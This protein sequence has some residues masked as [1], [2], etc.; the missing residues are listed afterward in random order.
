MASSDAG[1]RFLLVLAD[2]DTAVAREAITIACADHSAGRCTA[3]L[4]VAL[5]PAVTVSWVGASDWLQLAPLADPETPS[6]CDILLQVDKLL[7]EVAPGASVE[8]VC[9]TS[10][11]NLEA[12][13]AE[14][15]QAGRDGTDA[16]AA[17][18]QA[19]AAL[20]AAAPTSVAPANPPTTAVPAKEAAASATGGGRQQRRGRSAS[21]RK[22]TAAFRCATCATS[23]DFLFCE[24]T[25][26]GD[27]D[28]ELLCSSCRPA[29]FVPISLVDFLQARAVSP[30]SP[31]SLPRSAASLPAASRCT[32]L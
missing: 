28:A 2:G 21:V 17:N 30:T 10:A 13:A 25:T 22:S 31:L 5:V 16:A 15:E 9:H 27:P 24:P 4:H 8:V 11:A 26:A 20:S 29:N 32:Q 12:L 7:G 23:A 6:E 3:A 19:C 18:V 1:A 14:T